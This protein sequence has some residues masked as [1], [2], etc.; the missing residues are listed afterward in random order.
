MGAPSSPPHLQAALCDALLGANWSVSCLGR[1][2]LLGNSFSSYVERWECGGASR[3]RPAGAGSGAAQPPARLLQLARARAVIEVPV[4][5]HGY[6]VQS[7]FNDMSLH[8]FPPA[9][10]AG[11]PGLPP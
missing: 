9:R 8:L 5:D 1:I 4:P 10:L 6:P 2:A 7:A 3:A 11:V